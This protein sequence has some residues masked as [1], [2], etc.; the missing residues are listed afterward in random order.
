MSE[1]YLVTYLSLDDEVRVAF[2]TFEA[3]K[4]FVLNDLNDEQYKDEFIDIQGLKKR[5]EQAETVREL[6]CSNLFYS[7]VVKFFKTEG[8]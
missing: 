7:E 6:Y 8:K 3:A 1:I 5:L 2:D 4:A